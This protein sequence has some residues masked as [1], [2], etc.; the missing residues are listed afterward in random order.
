[1][2]SPPTA[3][4]NGTLPDELLTAFT[5]EMVGHRVIAWKQWLENIALRWWS[6]D[7]DGFHFMSHF[8]LDDVTRIFHMFVQ[9][10]EEGFTDTELMTMAFSWVWEVSN[11]CFDVTKGYRDALMVIIHKV[12]PSSV[13][14][15]AG[16][17]FIK[18][19]MYLRTNAIVALGHLWSFRAYCEHQTAFLLAREEMQLIR[20]YVYD[21]DVLSY[22][23]TICIIWAIIYL[24]IVLR[25]VDKATPSDFNSSGRSGKSA[26]GT[27]TKKGGEQWAM[28]NTPKGRIA[29]IASLKQFAHNKSNQLPTRKDDIVKMPALNLQQRSLAAQDRV[30][31]RRQLEIVVSTP[32]SATSGYASNDGS[33]DAS[34][35][36]MPRPRNISMMGDA[37]MRE[38]CDDPTVL[39]GWEVEVDG[40]G[41]GTIFGIKKTFG[42]P[43]RFKVRFE[44]GAAKLMKLKRSDRKGGIPFT[45]VKKT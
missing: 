31:S 13:T 15:A 4:M 22:A 19:A 34:P 37:L 33:E 32:A 14:D 44:D 29:M 28:K 36:T 43:T 23:S 21:S 45:P 3:M 17:E 26:E 16:L 39:I 5:Q 25:Q 41:K 11:T 12:V 27:S 42:R 18:L 38:S 6:S 20:R 30:A 8:L 7:A 2:A 1:M 9:F 35:G 10:G 40:R 24:F